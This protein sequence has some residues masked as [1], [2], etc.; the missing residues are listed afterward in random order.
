MDSITSAGQL[1]STDTSV[2]PSAHTSTVRPRRP[3]AS[4]H[5]WQRSSSASSSWKLESFLAAAVAVVEVAFAP[6]LGLANR[7]PRASLRRRPVSPQPPS[8]R[9]PPPTG[10]RRRP[11]RKRRRTSLRG[12][13]LERQELGGVRRLEAQVDAPGLSTV[14]RQLGVQSVFVLVG[15]NAR[16]LEGLTLHVWR[17]GQAVLEGEQVPGAQVRGAGQGSPRLGGGGRSGRETVS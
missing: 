12:T 11:R 8:P 2:S 9:N 7:H 10:R 13:V 17:Q 1:T 16:D 14:E 6:L 5:S 3:V 4:S 15:A